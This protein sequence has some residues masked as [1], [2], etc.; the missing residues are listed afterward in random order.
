[1]VVSNDGHVDQPAPDDEA[2]EFY[3]DV[4]EF[5]A[6][7]YTVFLTLMA[8][9]PTGPNRRLAV[10]KMS[11]EHAKV[12]AILFKQNVKAIEQQFGIEIAIPAQVLETHKIDLETM[13]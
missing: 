10:V 13:W 7:Q 8:T 12:M 9:S 2:T 3:T 1:M 5:A 11:P 6:N 4:Y